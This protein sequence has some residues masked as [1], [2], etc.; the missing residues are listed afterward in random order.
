MPSGDPRKIWIGW[1]SNWLYAKDEPTVLWR[2]GAIDSAD[3][4]AAPR[5]GGQL[6]MVQTPVRELQSLRGRDI[7]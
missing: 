7:L 3:A 5:Q 6:L 2:G 4:D 1:T